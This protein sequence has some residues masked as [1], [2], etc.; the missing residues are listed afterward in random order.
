MNT[1]RKSATYVAFAF[2]GAV[3]ALT[4]YSQFNNSE[5][6]VVI[7]ERSPVQLSSYVAPAVP[8]GQVD[9]T[10]AAE[11]SCFRRGAYYNQNKK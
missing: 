4:L 11:K 2:L 7:A 3:L 6:Q 9:L 10:Q 5:K 1:F 8:Q